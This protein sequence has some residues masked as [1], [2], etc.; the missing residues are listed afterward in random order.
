MPLL[1]HGIAVVTG[2]LWHAWRALRRIASAA[3]FLAS[4][5]SSYVAGTDL[6]LDGGLT[7]V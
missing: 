3:F 4:D 7:A 5:Q 2:G 6:P 1:R